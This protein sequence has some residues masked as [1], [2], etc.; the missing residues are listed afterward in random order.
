MGSG[1][2]LSLLALMAIAGLGI[3]VGCVFLGAWLFRM[4]LDIVRVALSIL[5]S[6]AAGIIVL[7]LVVPALGAAAGSIFSHGA[8]SVVSGLI[9]LAVEL[10]V[11]GACLSLIAEV[12]ARMGWAL[13]LFTF[14]AQYLL[15]GLI[16]LYLVGASDIPAADTTYAWGALALGAL[17][18]GGGYWLGSTAEGQPVRQSVGLVGGSG[19][20]ISGMTI[21][22]MTID[23]PPPAPRLDR[24]TEGSRPT[25][26]P[27]PPAAAGWLVLSVGQEKGRRFDV[28]QG[29]NRLGRSS[30]CDIRI[31]GDEEISREHSLIRVSGRSYELHDLAS[32]NGTFLNDSLVRG[33]RSLTDGDQIRIGNSV[34]TFKQVG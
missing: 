32:R 20:V 21:D 33:E 4:Q 27:S 14:G 5:A 16:S 11:F 17:L 22:A 28:R 6:V 8:A 12:S 34:L 26:V 29:D 30:E 15:L 31:T 7:L 24:P 9:V 3:T 10:L 25:E 19:G 23:A 1:A 13:A 2:S 18:L